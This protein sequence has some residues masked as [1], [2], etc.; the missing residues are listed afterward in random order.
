MVEEDEF[1]RWQSWRFHRDMFHSPT[2]GA[3][4]SSGGEAFVDRPL[5]RAVEHLEKEI[6]GT[7]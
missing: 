5:L 1:N 3:L 2:N 4:A 7:K 6:D